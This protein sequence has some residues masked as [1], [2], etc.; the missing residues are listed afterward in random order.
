MTSTCNLITFPVTSDRIILY[1]QTI[2][3]CCSTVA[4]QSLHQLT[5]VIKQYDISIPGHKEIRLTTLSISE[6]QRSSTVEYQ[7]NKVLPTIIKDVKKP[8]VESASVLYQ[9]GG[10]QTVTVTEYK[11]TEEIKQ[12]QG[13][14]ESRI[15]EVQSQIEKKKEEIKQQT[16]QFIARLDKTLPVVNNNNSLDKHLTV[17]TDVV[18]NN[19][20]GWKDLNKPGVRHDNN[21]V[22]TKL[23]VTRLPQTVS[24]INSLSTKPNRVSKPVEISSLHPVSSTPY[25]GDR[26]MSHPV[27]STTY[28]GDRPTSRPV[29][30]TTYP[31]DRPMSRPVSST[32]YP[33]DRPTSRPVSSTPYPDDKSMLRSVSSTTYPGNRPTLRPVYSTLHPETPSPNTKSGK[34][35]V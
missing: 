2:K 35:I 12:E 21:D 32:T 28:P 14:T 8:N 3:C 17:K 24:T 33:G 5:G 7:S 30:S 26:S 23:Q 25:P 1:V 31:G 9:L 4:A 15:K 6:Q 18:N 13:Q 16:S 20:G 27:S 10:K 19:D 34:P 29:S 22:T 11:G